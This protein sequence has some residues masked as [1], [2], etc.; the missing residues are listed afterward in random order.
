[1]YNPNKEL[2]ERYARVAI[3]VGL[4]LR[5]GQELIISAPIEAV[6]FVRAATRIAYNNG[7]KLVTAFYGDDDTALMRYT[8]SDNSQLDYANGWLAKGM[9]EAVS[10]GAAR[11]AVLGNNPTLFKDV[12]PKD[13]AIAG[14]ARGIAYKPLSKLTTGSVSNWS[15]VGYP[16]AAWAAQVFPGDENALEKLWDVVLKSC[17][18][19]A[20][21]TDPIDAWNEHNKNLHVRSAKMNEHRFDALRFVGGG[22]DLTV[23]LADN[24]VWEGGA[25]PTVDGHLYNANIPTEEVFTTPHSR[26]VNGVAKSTKPLL[27]RGTLIDGIEVTFKDG[28]AVEVKAEKGEQVLR[29][30]IAE[31]ENAC[32]L[33]EVALVPDNSPISNTGILFCETLFDENA[34]CHLAFGQSYSKCMIDTPDLNEEERA[35]HLLE[36][37]ANSS[38]IH[39]DWMIGGKD[40]TVFGVS[41][42]VELPIIQNGEWV[43]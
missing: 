4:K 18:C 37:G 27:Y 9:A 31:D 26:K 21:V 29:D 23:G 35:A 42:G 12:D 19:D 10:N 16:T 13:L 32:R 17:R 36:W 1:M 24:H 14:K 25:A 11:L 30:M 7:A 38:R 22:T 15:V 6:E 2:L 43:L 33:G 34:S 40:V 20:G 41:N 39:T 3:E 5:R 8:E 28:A